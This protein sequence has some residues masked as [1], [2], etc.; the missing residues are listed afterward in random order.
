[1]IPVDLYEK[2][3]L[4]KYCRCLRLTEYHLNCGHKFLHFVYKVKLNHFKIKYGISIPVNAVDVGLSISHIGPIIIHDK[5]VIGKNLR[6]NPCVVIGANGGLPPKIGDNVYIGPGAKIFGDIHIASNVS[7]GA[8]SVVNHNCDQE[9]G[10][11]VGSPA[12]LVRIK[13]V[14]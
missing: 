14:V 13:D 10:V 8:N 6:I 5:C 3:V 4:A 12:R 7:I 2:Q 1:M 9:G 11:Y